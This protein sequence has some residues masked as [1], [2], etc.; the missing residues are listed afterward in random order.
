MRRISLL[1]P[2]LL[3]LAIGSPFAQDQPRAPERVYS[4]A[5]VVQCIAKGTKGMSAR[6]KELEEQGYALVRNG[7]SVAPVVLERRRLQEQWCTVEAQCVSDRVSEHKQL[8]YGETFASCL[9]EA[10]SSKE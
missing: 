1:S 5:G 2:G 9:R 6:F 4:D 7:Q 8:A 3:L 10:G